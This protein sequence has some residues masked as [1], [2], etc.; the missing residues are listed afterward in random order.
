VSPRLA[1]AWSARQRQVADALAYALGPSA[2]RNAPLGARTTYRVGGPAAVLVEA[3]S[4]ADLGTIQRAL[5]GVGE[6]VPVLV[7]GQGSNLLVADAG[8]PGLVVVLGPGL[9]TVEVHGATVRA[10]VGAKLPVVARQCAAVGL[11]GLE[12]AVGVPGSVG[13]ALRMNAG[14]HGSDTAASLVRYRCYDLARGVADEADPARLAFGYRRSAL[15]PG[16][17]VVWAEFALT[18]GVRQEA[19]ELVA[20]IVRWRRA[21][22]PGGSNAGSVFTN[23]PADAAGRLVEQAGC[24][25]LRV[26]SAHV[27]DK[28][29]NFIQA[30]AG[31]SADDVRRLIEQVRSDVAERLGVHLETEVRLVGFSDVPLPTVAA[32]STSTSTGGRGR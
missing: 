4:E 14:G 17:V 32:V 7:V 9:S 8:F 29:A 27:S 10:G 20:E 13:G 11:R 1:G 3:G 21:H 31:G 30:D 6:A 24:K 22:Q 25:G 23:P 16:D 26:S 18:P 12:W 28:H 5:A 2:E 15:G 19:E